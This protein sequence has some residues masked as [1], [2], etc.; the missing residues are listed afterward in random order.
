[1]F[2]NVVLLFRTLSKHHVTDKVI[3]KHVYMTDGDIAT[4]FQCT[5][6][7]IK[8]HTTTM[9]KK[10]W[11]IQIDITRY[12]TKIWFSY[13]QFQTIVRSIKILAVV[14]SSVKQLDFFVP[15]YRQQIVDS[16]NGSYMSFHFSS[17]HTL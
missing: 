3:R 11:I 15:K 8:K 1:M 4:L 6:N 2:A 5:C 14:N 7:N 12:V 9:V 10:V 17:W 13:S 16:L